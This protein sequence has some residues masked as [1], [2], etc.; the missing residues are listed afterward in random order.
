MELVQVVPPNMHPAG[1]DPLAAH[2]VPPAGAHEDESQLEGDE[3]LQADWANPALA[4]TKTAKTKS[5]IFIP[6]RIYSSTI[7]C[8]IIPVG[9]RTC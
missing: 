7:N 2:Q 4:R 8:Y 1:F 9:D 6:N 5:A 3:L